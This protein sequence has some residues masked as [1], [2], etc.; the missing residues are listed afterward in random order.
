MCCISIVVVW[1]AVTSCD[2]VSFR[3]ARLACA[4]DELPPAR[5]GTRVACYWV[6][7]VVGLPGFGLSDR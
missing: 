3:G 5:A 2:H 1:L 6:A 4:T 7:A